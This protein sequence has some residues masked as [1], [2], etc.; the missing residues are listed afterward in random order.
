MTDSIKMK[1]G[2]SFVVSNLDIRFPLPADITSTMRLER[3]SDSQIREFKRTASPAMFSVE[4]IYEHDWVDKDDNVSGDR[5]HSVNISRDRWRYYVVAWSNWNS[6][7]IQFQKAVNLVPPGIICH[8]QCITNEDFGRGPVV[9]RVFDGSTIPSSCIP[10]PPRLQLLDDDIFVSWKRSL[11]A[12]NSFDRERHPGIS[13]AVDFYD[14]FKRQQM[15]EE[16]HILGNFM[17][18]EMIL[19]HNP[20]GREIGDSLA[21]QIC[22]KV[23]LLEARM[24]ERLLYSMFGPPGETRTIW[25]KLYALRSVI[26]HGSV[27]DFNGNLKLLRDLRTA[28]AFLADA[29]GRVLRQALEEPQLFDDLKA[30]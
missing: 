3:A 2:Y 11:N 18:L 20:N 6:E 9:G 22:H 17:V 24:S 5:R 4:L 13:R 15:T 29:T 10:I 21:H 28:S 27:A 7:F 16:L 1:G 26:A 12:L 14:R 25:K 8:M 19:T 30:I 23:A